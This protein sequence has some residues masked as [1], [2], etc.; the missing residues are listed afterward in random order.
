MVSH[1]VLNSFCENPPAG[2]EYRA[3]I[4]KVVTE[5]NL[6]IFQ[7]PCPELC[8][9]GLDRNSIYPCS[10]EATAYERYCESLIEPIIKNIDEY[11]K[12]GIEISGIIGIE[13][14]PSCSVMEKGAIMMKVLFDHLKKKG[15]K[16]SMQTDMPI[17]KG[18]NLF[19][20]ELKK[21]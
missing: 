21:I 8:Y 18:E 12:N 10:D 16:I 9:Q 7:L 5:K 13:T 14:S 20:E 3:D 11:E 4:L 2:D 1:C 17:R 15:I 6:S 19:I